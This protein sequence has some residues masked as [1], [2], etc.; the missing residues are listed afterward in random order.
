MEIEYVDAEG[1]KNGVTERLRVPLVHFPRMKM[2]DVVRN[3]FGNNFEDE[4]STESFVLY[5]MEDFH[6]WY[7]EQM[8]LIKEA[9]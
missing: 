2:K 7:V 6:K 3:Y 1:I 8:S 9:L 5:A 4:D